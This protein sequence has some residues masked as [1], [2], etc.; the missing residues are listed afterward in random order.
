MLIVVAEAKNSRKQTREFLN[1]VT[2]KDIMTIIS[3]PPGSD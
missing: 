3:S 1:H 2:L